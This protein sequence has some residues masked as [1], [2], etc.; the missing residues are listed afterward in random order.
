MTTDFNE[1]ISLEQVRSERGRINVASQNM[2]QDSLNQK[3]NAAKKTDE[4]DLT[5]KSPTLNGVFNSVNQIM[6]GESYFPANSMIL[7][8]A[9]DGSK[10]IASNEVARRE[11]YRTIQEFVSDPTHSI[12]MKV[13]KTK[14]K[15]R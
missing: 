13:R 14:A 3:L 10:V 15:E 11:T 8:M 9:P 5:V 6:T 1:T 12:P 4:M 2:F 7:I